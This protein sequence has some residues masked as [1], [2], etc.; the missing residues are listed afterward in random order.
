MTAAHSIR[1][2]ATTRGAL[3]VATQSP[4]S[5][6]GDCCIHTGFERG[7]CSITAARPNPL[8]EVI[9]S[10]SVAAVASF[11]K[12]DA[13]QAAKRSA[14]ASPS[15]FREA[16]TPNDDPAVRLGDGIGQPAFVALLAMRGCEKEARVVPAIRGTH[17]NAPQPQQEAAR[18]GHAAG[19]QFNAADARSRATHLRA[20]WSPFAETHPCASRCSGVGP[21][22]PARRS[23]AR[24]AAPFNAV[25]NEKRDAHGRP[26]GYRDN[27]GCCGRAAYT[28]ASTPFARALLPKALAGTRWSAMTA[29]NSDRQRPARFAAV[30]CRLPR[31]FYYT[32]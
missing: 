13:T 28:V 32:G 15:S 4:R 25:S 8:P 27:A 5:L 23:S 1:A 21:E 12:P 2:C 10:G 11:T 22:M 9:A 26:V 7:S 16:A 29:P 14:T 20:G 31:P 3:A 30:P 6:A 18:V 17:S 24:P 19:R